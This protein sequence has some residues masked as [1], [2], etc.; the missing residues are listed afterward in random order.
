[1]LYTYVSSYISGFGKP[2]ETILKSH[3]K[4]VAIVRHLDGLII[5]QTKMEFSELPMSCFNNTYQ[6]LAISPT[7]PKNSYEI[8]L[9][10]FIKQC[11][12]DLIGISHNLKHSKYKSF[13]ILPVD[14]NS[15]VSINFDL[16]KKVEDQ[17]EQGLHL[18]VDIRKHDC[19]V[20]LS[21][22]SE[23]L[24]LLLFKLSYNRVTEKTLN[25]GELRPELCHI[26]AWISDLQ[27]NDIIID[28][29]CGHGSIPKEI[30][31]NFKYNMLF[32]SD[33]DDT[34][35]SKLKLEFKKN[36]KNLFIKQRDALNL[37]YF[38][39]NFFDKIIT[40][41]PWNMYHAEKG[42]FSI[43]YKKMLV[44]FYRILKPRGI[45][46]IL[47]GNVIDFEKALDNHKFSLVEK[48]H[49]LVNGK[50]ANV[51]KLIKL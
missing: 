25:K 45:C 13:K 17:I 4:D 28:P 5:Y 18:K 22:R 41:P 33:I 16:V 35:I 34:L 1:M 40:D 51:Y 26:L 20:I 43:F 27:P 49:I 31:K 23:G 19:D 24:F 21:R 46:T 30:V 29:F 36:K 39:D 11:N 37:A 8:A 47:M 10:N 12:I 7:N 9:K 32:A 44:E 48:Y 38:E 2:I 42:D 14:G 50:K 3:I 6:V 15:P